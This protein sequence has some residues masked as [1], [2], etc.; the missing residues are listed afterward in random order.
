[1]CLQRKMNS[2]VCKH[3][4]IK[5]K[6]VGRL[7]VL[8]R[9]RCLF[10]CLMEQYWDIIHGDLLMDKEGLILICGEI[11]KVGKSN[12]LRKYLPSLASS[13]GSVFG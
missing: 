6:G 8:V 2:T 7:V 5:G 11:Y 3:Q 4:A 10:F 1:M 12:Q 9:Y 13:L